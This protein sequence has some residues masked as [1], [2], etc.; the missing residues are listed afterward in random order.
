MKVAAI[1]VIALLAECAAAEPTFNGETT[2]FEHS[3]YIMGETAEAVFEGCGFAAN[4]DVELSVEV[5]DAD[6]NAVGAAV[7]E[8]IRADAEGKWRKTVALPSAAYGAF[9][10]YAKANAVPLPDAGTRGGGYLSY[11]ILFDPKK[12]PHIPE[13]EAF[14]GVHGARPFQAAFMGAHWR[15]DSVNQGWPNGDEKSWR[16]REALLAADGWESYFFITASRIF[17]RPKFYSQEALEFFGKKIPM[18]GPQIATEKGAKY[19]AEALANLARAAVG[20]ENR[21]QRL[22]VYEIFWEPELHYTCSDEIVRAAKL[23]YRAIKDVDPEGIVAAPS[24]YTINSYDTFREYFDKGLAD[25]MDAVSIHPYG[26]VEGDDFRGKIRAIRRLVRERKGRDLDFYGTESGIGADV[27]PES[28]L[29]Q[30]QRWARTLCTLLG[31]GFR[32]HHVFYG[33]DWGSDGN[34]VRKGGSGLMYNLDYPKHRWAPVHLSPKPSFAAISAFSL[35][36]DGLRP[37]C[38]ISDLGGSRTGYAYADKAGKRCVAA[39]WDVGDGSEAEFVSGVERT[40]ISDLMGNVR[41]VPSPGGRVKI[42]LSP[43]PVY[44]LNANP[45]L[46]GA[47]G[48]RAKELRNKVREEPEPL[49]IKGV[50]PMFKDGAAGLVAEVSN[51]DGKAMEVAVESR[52]RGIPE[53][54]QSRKVTIAAHSSAKVEI[55]F[56]ERAFPAPEGFRAEVT[57]VSSVHLAQWSG[58]VNYLLAPRGGFA[59]A[60]A[61]ADGSRISLSWNAKGLY[62]VIAASTNAL[63]VKFARCAL[64]RRSANGF[65]DT[66]TE[67]VQTMRFAG[68]L[69]SRVKTYHGSRPAGSVASARAK[70][71]E[72][73]GRFEHRL[74]VPWQELGFSVPPSDGDTIR[75]SFPGFFPCPD[76]NPKSFGFVV[77]GIR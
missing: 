48:R 7:S 57:A 71:I 66:M 12:R 64:A 59:G 28:E 20:R 26:D 9:R 11:A 67:A 75:M 50:S 68:G 14:L 31:E 47:E 72:V 1:A 32:F 37:T 46:W 18:I 24:P 6:G 58:A 2:R 36:V 62:A 77:L 45:S 15:L 61:L 4:E 65:A 8:K 5:K 76:D 42:A 38:E 51:E 73:E 54:R 39:L 74:F 63:E 35:A 60:S 33:F 19:C 17:Q 43:S 22:R 23:A 30:A 55:V 16:E 40:T 3:C 13:D 41:E 34:N 70:V 10:V 21:G 53:A 56:D 44:V 29:R 25:Y 27:T 69:A 52:I 49:R